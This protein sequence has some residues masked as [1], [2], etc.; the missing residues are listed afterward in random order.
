MSKSLAWLAPHD[1]FPGVEQT[2]GESDPIPGLLAAGGQLDAQHLR[3]AYSQGIFPWFSAG[4]PIL[5]WSP[6]PRMVLRTDAFRLHR[7]LRKTLQRFRAT[8]GCEIRV[9]SA[10]EAVIRS[11]AQTPRD[12][13]DGTWIVESIVQAYCELHRQGDAHSVETWVDGAL[14]GGLYGVG[15]GR[16]FYGESMFARVSDASKVALAYLV[17]FLQRH[18]VEM[19]DCQ[20]ETGHLASLGA[21]PIPRSRFLE[22][23]HRATAR[24]GIGSWTVA[25]PLPG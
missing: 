12:G 10:F 15:I 13:Q 17:A 24:P 22:H 2:W 8:P 23:V 21:A 6:D 18:G 7:S 9:D 1:P 4:Q 19:V 5:W 3:S 20:Q 25:A 11:C 14:V 16:M